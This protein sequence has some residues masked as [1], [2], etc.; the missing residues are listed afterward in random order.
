MTDMQTRDDG[1]FSIR[2][3]DWPELDTSL[4]EDARNPVP[5][6][7]L[8]HLPSQWRQWVEDTAQSAGAPVD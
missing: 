2:T 1:G 6:F 5:A 7:P 4:L 8:E 3:S